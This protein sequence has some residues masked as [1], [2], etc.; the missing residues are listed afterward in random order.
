MISVVIPAFNE[1]QSIAACLRSLAAQRTR[2]KFEVILVDNASTDRTRAIAEE[3]QGSLNLRILSEPRK[4]RGQAR[5]TGWREAKG[6]IILSTDA[7]AEV[8]PHWIQRYASLFLAYPRTA[9]FTG[10]GRIVDLSPSQNLIAN[11]VQ[12]PIALVFR[13][14]F[15]FYCLNGYNFAVR[16]EAYIASGGFDP[17]MDA[18][19]DLDLTKRLLVHGPIRFTAKNRVR[20]SGRRFKHGLLRGAMDYPRTYVQKYWFKKKWVPL[21]D[22]R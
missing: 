10:H 3:F 4:G 14:L 13:M 19:D 11:L 20:V 5:R 1:E 17:T 12:R 6:D 22:V 2:E 8:P 18:Q 16:R 21:D 9:G 7:D 15:G